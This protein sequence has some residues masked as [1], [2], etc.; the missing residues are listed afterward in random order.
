[1]IT[2]YEDVPD[3]VA[4]FRASGEVTAADHEKVLVPAVEERLARHRKLSLLYHLGRDFTGFTAG[5]MLDDTRIGLKHLASWERI[6]LVSD[7]P[8]IRHMVQV[9]GFVIPA[10]IRVFPDDALPDAKRW[11]SGS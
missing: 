4:A 1:M 5:A 3:D 7:V 2:C 11:V 10:K 9:M 6:A 8:W